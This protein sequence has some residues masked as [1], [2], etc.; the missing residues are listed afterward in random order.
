MPL[1]LSQFGNSL[2]KILPFLAQE[3]AQ[4]DQIRQWLQRSLQEIAAREASQKRVNL[5]STQNAILERTAGALG[6]IYKDIPG[7]QFSLPGYLKSVLPSVTQDIVTGPE[8]Q[9]AADEVTN[10]L[11]NIY[12][13][14][15][16]GQP[17]DVNALRAVVGR[18]AGDIPKDIIT[19]AAANKLEGGS[20]A[21]TSRGLDLEASG[22]GLRKAELAQKNKDEKTTKDTTNLG[23]LKEAQNDRDVAIQ[24]YGG[25]GQI[26]GLMPDAKRA[27]KASIKNANARI[28]QASRTMGVESPILTREE[29]FK[30]GIVIVSRF[31]QEGVLP[32]WY[33]LLYQGYDPDFV[34]GLQEV[35]EKPNK[36]AKTTDKDAQTRALAL[37]QALS[38]GKVE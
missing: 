31:A 34:F 17:I 12:G 6:D 25:V 7:G 27:L 18:I 24:K 36:K 26:F 2:S 10:Q 8:N 33:T 5:D 20:Q 23:I 9:A 1:D 30:A 22:Q 14:F 38:E 37:L 13:Q 16:A 3:K 32:D 4:R 15:Q 29:M 35:F 19:K 21:L 28:D 11:T